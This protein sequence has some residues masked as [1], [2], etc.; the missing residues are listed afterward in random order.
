MDFVDTKTPPVKGQFE[1]KDITLKKY[2][3]IFSPSEIGK[4]SSKIKNVCDS[5]VN[6]KGYVSKGIILI[7]SQWIDGGLIPMALALEEMG[8]QRFGQNAKSLFKNPVPPVDVRTMKPRKK[9]LITA[10]YAMITGDPRLSPNNNFELKAITSEDNIYG[11][12]K[13]CSYLQSRF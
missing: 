11:D 2:G 7:Y 9:G 1:Y 5:I 13:G 4:Y 12:S 10:K 6:S 8:F 3:R